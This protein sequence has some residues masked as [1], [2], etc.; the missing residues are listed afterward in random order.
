MTCGGETP[1]CWINPCLLDR[2]LAAGPGVRGT[3][4][5]GVGCMEGTHRGP[6]HPR[7]CQQRGEG[8]RGSVLGGA[9]D[10]GKKRRA[11]AYK[12]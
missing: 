2:V 8:N 4:K 11:R 10:G 5:W 9:K 12:G 1:A 7:A 6:L 3:A